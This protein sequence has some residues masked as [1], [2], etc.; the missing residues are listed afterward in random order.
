LFWLKPLG[1]ALVAQMA[2]TMVNAFVTRA[3]G[4]DADNKSIS[5]QP[6]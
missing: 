3:R 4:L 5:S 1:D 2:V 6:P